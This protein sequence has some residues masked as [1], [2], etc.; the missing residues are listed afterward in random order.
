VRGKLLNELLE[1]L[2]RRDSGSG[3]APSMLSLLPV[4]I[5]RSLPAEMAQALEVH[6]LASPPQTL[7]L[8]RNF[9]GILTHSLDAE[10][11]LRQFLLM[12]REIVSIN[13]AVIFMR[14]PPPS[15]CE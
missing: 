5:A 6:H 14:P 10:A 4:P 11:M 9:S 7:S 2:W 8:L 13:R 3:S 15:F 12:L 1:R